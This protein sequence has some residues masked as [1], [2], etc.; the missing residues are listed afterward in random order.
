[1]LSAGQTGIR[2]IEV[3]QVGGDGRIGAA[4]D[5]GAL[6]V[7]TGRADCGVPGQVDLVLEVLVA[8]SPVGAGAPFP[9]Y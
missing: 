4:A 9:S 7:V 3:G 6:Q 2:V 8:V 5:G 1:M